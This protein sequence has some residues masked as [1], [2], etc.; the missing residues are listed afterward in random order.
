[1]RQDSVAAW[2]NECAIRDPQS[3]ERVGNDRDDLE[4]LFG[5]YYRYCDRTSSRD[6]GSREF[7]LCRK[8]A[9]V[10][11]SIFSSFAQ[12]DADS[13]F[14]WHH[15]LP[16]IILLNVRWY[17][18]YCLSYRAL[19]E[20]IAERGVEVD[21]S[22]INRWVLKFAPELNKRIHRFLNPTSHSFDLNKGEVVCRVLG[23]SPAPIDKSLYNPPT[24]RLR[25]R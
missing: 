18:R 6:K 12:N 4:S 5:S 10:G 22:T 15:F 21:H 11:S 24:G 25:W 9:K 13:L 1:M 7:W 23:R 14:K 19:E 3:C 17:C 8:N 16:E 20:M 2:L